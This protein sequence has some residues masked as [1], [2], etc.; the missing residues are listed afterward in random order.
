MLKAGL[1]FMDEPDITT[2]DAD[3]TGESQMAVSQREVEAELSGQP[4]AQEQPELVVEDV[5]PAPDPDHL[6]A[7]KYKS[8]EE[9][10][11]AYQ[12][13]ESKLGSQGREL[14]EARSRADTAEGYNQQWQQW[15]SSNTPQDN[16]DQDRRE[17][18]LDPLV[19]EQALILVDQGMEEAQAIRTA[20]RLASSTEN[21][22]D[23]KISIANARYEDEYTNVVRQRQ[24]NAAAEA[25]ALETGHDD[26]LLRPDWR[27]VAATPEFR[28]EYKAHGEPSDRNSIELVYLKTKTRLPQRDIAA[29]AEELEAAAQAQ[30]EAEKDAA[31]PSSAVGPVPKDARAGEPTDEDE[32]TD[33]Y[34]RRGKRHVL[35][36]G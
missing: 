11:S 1:P 18:G 19:R 13:L 28:Q 22:V 17:S 24:A 3:P 30:V 25:L 4:L 12:G 9:M 7:G 21:M 20:K 35:M 10:E 2:A 8:I 14:G 36:G 32:I 26:T 15:A 33:L 29:E 16:Q 27:E 6:Y 31:S 23:R 5:P 34:S